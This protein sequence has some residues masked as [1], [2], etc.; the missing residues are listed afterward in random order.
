MTDDREEMRITEYGIR[1]TEHGIRNTER[2]LR[3]AEWLISDEEGSHA[4]TPR[5]KQLA[6]M[7]N[8]VSLFILYFAFPLRLC[9][10][11]RRYAKR[12]GQVLA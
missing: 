11:P 6:L 12:C 9:A 4:K 8:F 5:R 10:R 7:N 2:G 3:N 1:N